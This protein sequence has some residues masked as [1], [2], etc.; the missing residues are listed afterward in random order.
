MK[1]Y[2]LSTTALLMILAAP[3]KSFEC[4]N[5]YVYIAQPLD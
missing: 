2:I 3:A 1:R 5:Y 4:N